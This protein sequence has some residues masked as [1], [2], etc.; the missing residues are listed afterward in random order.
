MGRPKQRQ[1]IVE[2]P[3][4]IGDLTDLRYETPAVEDQPEPEE[5]PI[6][7]QKHRIVTEYT[8]QVPVG[9]TATSS[10]PPKNTPQHIVPPVMQ[11]SGPAD[12][13]QEFLDKV[14]QSTARWEMIIYRLPRYESDNRIDPMS[15]K[16]VGAMPFTWDYESEIQRRWA[17][18]NE[19]NNFLIVMRKDGLFVTNGTL[20]VFSCEPLPVEE[21][22]PS[23]AD[24][25][26][27]QHIVATVAAPYSAPVEAHPA[28]TL[29]EQL[30]EVVDLFQLAQK[31]NGN[32][33]A[34]PATVAAPMDPEAA[35]F[36]LLAKDEHAVAKLS[37][38]LLGKFF[39]DV[40]EERD[41]WAE[42][43]MEAIRNGQAAE[44]LK[45]GI[46]SLFQGFGGF[47][48]NNNPQ[49]QQQPQQQQQQ[50]MVA[51]TE[52]LP[53]QPLAPTEELLSYVL[54]QCHL[55]APRE[56][57]ADQVIAFADQINETDPLQSVDW[58]IRAFAL[59]PTDEA[60]MFVNQSVPGSQ[61]VTELPHAKAWTA[62]LQQLL[63]QNYEVETE[64][65]ADDQHQPEPENVG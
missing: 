34:N 1:E 46:N 48:P 9:E 15:R 22:I 23:G 60:L 11:S 30:K 51:P 43:A 4:F 62:E 21:R 35:V 45:V 36:Q 18:P 24:Q 42:V 32:G 47:F 29:K 6:A 13:V 19:A 5:A 44:L 17:R 16:R 3:D 54:Q 50:P 7:T 57:V 64:G 14:S 40:K 53:P 65:D 2:Q 27:P 56:A 55:N 25:P 28:P 41:P 58:Y 59:M 38:G 33:I 8:R 63:K 37:K 52:S 26:A 61:R 10:D 39:G 20:P 31:L 12:E 49:P